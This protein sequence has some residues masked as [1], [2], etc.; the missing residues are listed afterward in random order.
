MIESAASIAPRSPPLTGASSIATPFAANAAAIVRVGPGSIE[1]MSI[2]RE[3][4][5]TP[6]ITPPAP[7]RTCSTS[8]VSGSIVIVTSLPAATDAGPSARTAPAATTSS[9]GPWPRECTAT[10]KP[11]ASRLRAIGLPMMPSPMNPMRSPTRQ[12]SIAASAMSSAPV[13]DREALGQLFL[14]DAQGRVRHHVPP[15]DERGEPVVD[16]EA[17]HLLHRLV[18]LVEGTERLEGLPVLHELE[19]AEQ[20]DVAGAAHARMLRRERVVVRAHHRFEPLRVADEVVVLD[21]LHRGDRRRH[22][23]RMRVVG[24]PAPEHVLVEVLGHVRREAD[25]AERR[26]RGRQPLRRRDDVGHDVPVVHGEPLARA[27]P[28]A[29]HLVGDQHDA[30]AR[31][32]LAHALQVAVGRD[33]DAVRAGDRLDDERRDRV[34]PL[35]LD[36]LLEQSQ[37]GLRVVDLTLRAVVRI[38]HVHHAGHRRLFVRPASRVAGEHHRAVRRAVVAAIAREHLL[39]A[40]HHLR[41]LH[42]VLVRLGPGQREERLLDVAGPQPREPTAEHRPPLERLERRDVRQLLG[43][44]CDRLGDPLVAVADVHAHQLRAEVEPA[45]SVD[46]VHVDALGPVDRERRR[47]RLRLPVVQGESLRVRD[48]LV[49]AERRALGCHGWS[50]LAQELATSAVGVSVVAAISAA[51]ASEPTM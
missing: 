29:H 24:Q 35:Q 12:S 14:V 10:G 8:A 20:A 34:R 51:P 1:L 21:H 36:R 11:A 44:S 49:G 17:V 32:Q 22:A 25:G 16:Q 48:D 50:S 31:A 19:D 33:Q 28:P 40:G 3:P 46:P 13:D 18:H 4:S 42:R 9:T 43:L 15:P 47:L 37:C 7:T 30:V 39:A 26:V 23:E 5:E 27:A 41:D 38:E 6:S 45:T 2:T